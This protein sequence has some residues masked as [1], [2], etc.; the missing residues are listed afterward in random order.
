M[1]E[2]L[3]LSAWSSAYT[4]SFKPMLFSLG[5][6]ITHT[7]AT[8]AHHQVVD[9]HTAQQGFHAL[10][11]A[12]A[13]TV[14]D[15][16]LE[17]TMNALPSARAH[18]VHYLSIYT[19]ITLGT[20][21]LGVIQSINSYWGGL[22]ACRKIHDGMLDNVMGST[23]RFFSTTPTGRILNRF[24][25]DIDTIDGSLTSSLETVLSQVGGLIASVAL[26]ASIVPA[27][28]LPAAVI[29]Y[30]YYRLTVLYLAC[31]RDLRRIEATRRSPIFSGFGELL[32]GITTVRA[33]SAERRFRTNLFAQVDASQAAF[34]HLWMANR[35]LL[36]RMDTMG[37]ASVFFT[38]VLALTGAVPAGLAG[39]AILSAQQFVEGC[40]WISRFQ[41]Q[42]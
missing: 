14:N 42:L 22:K 18:P 29:S 8:A 17:V 20:A 27:F 35:W 31:T 30:G 39:V 10:L 32:E 36:V 19:A 3:W 15:S 13:N 26:V 12:S 25:R 41:G 21:L 40:Y 34:Y 11:T 2:R 9:H 28:L 16:T 38:S 6:T 23:M 33:Y 5:S 1:G 24:S 7:T 4:D 37:A